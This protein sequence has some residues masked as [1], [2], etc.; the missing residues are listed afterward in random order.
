MKR[1]IRR[2]LAAAAVIGILIYAGSQVAVNL[3]QQIETADALEVTVQQTVSAQGWFIREQVPVTG[4]GSGT[5]EY[6]VSDGEK[7]AQGESSSSVTI[8]SPRC[9]SSWTPWNMPIP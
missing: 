9:G 3:T 2:I 4:S 1:T 7:V 8:R 6:L 5:A